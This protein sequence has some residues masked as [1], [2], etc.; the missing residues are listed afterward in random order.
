MYATQCA[1]AIRLTAPLLQGDNKDTVDNLRTGS[2]TGDPE[3]DQFLLSVV[4]D[5]QTSEHWEVKYIPR[6][7]NSLARNIAKW[8]SIC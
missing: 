2:S 4:H 1:K 7:G 5:L 8:A 3:V 6:S